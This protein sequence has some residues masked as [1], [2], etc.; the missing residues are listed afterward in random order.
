MMIDNTII[1]IPGTL[2]GVIH[3]IKALFK[4]IIRFFLEI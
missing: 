4:I 3:M 2:F 1:L